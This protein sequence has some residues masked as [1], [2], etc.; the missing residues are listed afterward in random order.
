MVTTA[1]VQ[2]NGARL[3]YVDRG[4]G[5]AVVLVHGSNS[6][7]RIWADHFEIIA[8][9]HRVVALTQ[10]YFGLSAWPDDGQRFSIQ[11][12]A[13]DLA[14]FIAALRLARV[15]VV[16]WS[17]GATVSLTMAAQYPELV[18]RLFL[19]EPALD[20]MVSDPV[21]AQRAADD[22]LEMRR[23]AARRASAGDVVGAVK[24]FVDSVNESDGTFESL[25]SPVQT[26][27]RDNAR[28]LPLLFAAPPPPRI[29]CDDLSRLS[30]PVTIALG[31]ESRSCF[32]ILA[33]CT[34]GCIP[35]AKLITIERARHMWPIQDPAAFSKLVLTFLQGS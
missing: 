4:A 17:Y 30:L 3:S 29:T 12:H 16:G 14:A 8:G 5:R 26:L 10:R 32:T 15:S 27:F 6:D 33:N 18:E 13:N 21:A 22:R 35:S 2:V 19:Y 20:S 7:L 28:M 25:P 11:N 23:E 31:G 24:L 1:D 9:A 34:A